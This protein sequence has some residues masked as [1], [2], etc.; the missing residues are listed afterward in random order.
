[1]GIFIY[2][3]TATGKSVLAQKYSNVINMESTIYKYIGSYKENENL[4]GTQ[5][6]INNQWPD[7]YFKELTNLCNSPFCLEA[8]FL[9]WTPSETDLSINLK[10][11]NKAAS[12][13]AKSFASTATLTFLAAVRIALLAD[14]FLSLASS[15]VRL[16]LICDLMF[17]INFNSFFFASAISLLNTYK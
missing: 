6:K 11:F 12:A 14:L 13:A 17:A 1:M 5:R 4:K 15:F 3:F 2:A 10:A 7:N 9:C 16:R 8:V